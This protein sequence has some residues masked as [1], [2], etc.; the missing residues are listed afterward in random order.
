MKHNVGRQSAFC[1]QHSPAPTPD[2]GLVLGAACHQRLQSIKI[3]LPGSHRG[4]CGSGI[5]RSPQGQG[6]QGMRRQCWGSRGCMLRCRGQHGEGSPGFSPARLGGGDGGRGSYRRLQ[7]EPSLCVPAPHTNGLQYSAPSHTRNSEHLC[8]GGVK[9][10]SIIP[11]PGRAPRTAALQLGRHQND[12][13]GLS[14]QSAAPLQSL[15]FSW[16]GTGKE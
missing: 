2:G 11:C 6:S 14:K 8:I 10:S 4:Q 1:T 9:A 12:L 3:T 13:E 15:W 7:A 5:T 16:P